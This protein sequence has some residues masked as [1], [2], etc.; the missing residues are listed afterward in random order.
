METFA[1]AGMQ[2]M[3]LWEKLRALTCE[4][5]EREV[6]AGLAFICLDVLIED[7]VFFL[8]CEVRFAYGSL[9]VPLP[10]FY[11]ALFGGYKLN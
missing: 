11:P 4:V 6:L 10:F 7:E 1:Q 9:R 3:R 8:R 2:I 5:E